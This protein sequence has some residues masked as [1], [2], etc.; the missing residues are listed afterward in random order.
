MGLDVLCCSLLM[1]SDV[2]VFFNPIRNE[3]IL[4]EMKIHF[5][6]LMVLCV[7]HLQLLT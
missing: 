5:E 6:V 7:A 3:S 4:K 1:H 2:S